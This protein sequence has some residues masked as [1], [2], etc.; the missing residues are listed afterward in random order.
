MS[1]RGGSALPGKDASLQRHTCT[2]VLFTVVAA[3]VAA[4]VESSAVTCGTQQQCCVGSVERSARN[5]TET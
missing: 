2:G 3:A 1:A 4:P 5:K